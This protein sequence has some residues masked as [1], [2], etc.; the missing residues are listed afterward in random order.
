MTI[1]ASL[2]RPRRAGDVEIFQHPPA[3]VVETVQN[4]AEQHPDEV[5]ISPIMEAVSPPAPHAP[6]LPEQDTTTLVR[7][8]TVFEAQ[9]QETLVEYIVIQN[10]IKLNT[11]HLVLYYF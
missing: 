1:S 4:F 6:S 3:S 10:C 11:F 8:M 5:N 2:K 9:N 7:S